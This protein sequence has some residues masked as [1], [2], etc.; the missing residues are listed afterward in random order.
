MMSDDALLD[1]LPIEQRLALAYGSRPA[2]AALL[3]VLALDAR[4]AGTVR[5][6]REPVLGQIRLAWW[7]ENLA[8]GVSC[9]TSPDPLLARIAAD[10]GD[11]A[12]LIAL[13]DAWE[14]M[15]GQGPV[16]SDALAA[17]AEA[18]ALALAAVGARFTQAALSG[19][20]M[21]A[22]RNWA[23]ADL[24]ARLSQPAERDAAAALTAV[25]DWRRPA[26]PRALRALA[27]LHGL[28]RRRHDGR[29]L[30]AEKRAFAVA[31]RLGL[32]NV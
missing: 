14:G 22:A 18:R 20:V 17:L 12:A 32:L 26:L 15:V 25:Q 13:V 11:L 7:R 29:P 2:R 6:A 4:L 23:L 1:L 9:L 19:E 31:L 3:T 30:L 16:G 8:A 21:R 27:V 24:A 5:A 28:A 10:Q